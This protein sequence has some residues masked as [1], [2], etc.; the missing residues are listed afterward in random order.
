MTIKFIKWYIG[1]LIK[2][3][4]IINKP[5][6]MFSK[7]LDP[8]LKNKLYDDLRADPETSIVK[9]RDTFE[10][11]I[12]SSNFDMMK[13]IFRILKFMIKDKIPAKPKFYALILIKELMETQ[14]PVIVEYFIKKLMSRLFLIAQFDM[15]NMDIN[16]GE[17]CLK[18]YYSA[19]SKENSDF[20]LKFFMLLLECWKHWQE[21]YADKY[22]KIKE[23]CDKLKP[24]FPLNDIYYDYIE[25]SATK[26]PRN[27]SN[28]VVFN[29]ISEMP[30]DYHPN[31][32]IGMKSRMSVD[33]GDE[34]AAIKHNF[35]QGNSLTSNLNIKGLENSFETRKSLNEFLQGNTEE[36]FYES[37]T[38]FYKLIEVEQANLT[39]NKAS[40]MK[41]QSYDENSKLKYNNEISALTALIEILDKFGRADLNFEDLKKQVRAIDKKYP[42]VS[43]PKIVNKPSS[44]FQKE[45]RISNNNDDEEKINEMNTVKSYSEDLNFSNKKRNQN[46]VDSKSP[47]EYKSAAQQKGRV[48]NFPST[49]GIMEESNEDDSNIVRISNDPGSSRIMIESTEEP[50]NWRTSIDQP[51]PNS[52]TTG[53]TQKIET[54]GKKADK[55]EGQEWA[56]NFES[57]GQEDNAN[58]NAFGEFEGFGQTG[59]SMTQRVDPAKV[60]IKHSNSAKKPSSKGKAN[61]F[62]TK[63]QNDKG[64]EF[65]STKKSLFNNEDPF[66]KEIDEDLNNTDNPFF[67]SDNHRMNTIIEESRED[68]DNSQRSISK[69][70]DPRLQKSI[71]HYSD[72][73]RTGNDDGFDTNI[74]LKFGDF[75]DLI[76]N[77]VGRPSNEDPLM[78][79]ANGIKV[80]GESKN[81]LSGEFHLQSKSM[82]TSKLGEGNTKNKFSNAL[83]NGKG[84]SPIASKN[85]NKFS[86]TPVDDKN[87]QNQSTSR[88]KNP[89]YEDAFLEA[90]RNE[91]SP[92]DDGEVKHPNLNMNKKKETTKTKH[93]FQLVND[94]AKNKDSKHDK[95]NSGNPP[96][97]FEFDFNNIANIQESHKN[98]DEKNNLFEGF[99]NEKPVFG[100]HDFPS[101]ST[102]IN[103]RKLSNSKINPNAKNQPAARNFEE[104]RNDSYNNYE[105]DIKESEV[106]DFHKGDVPFENENMYM[107]DFDHIDRSIGDKHSS[108][109]Y[110][111]KKIDILGKPIA[112]SQITKKTGFPSN[113]KKHTQESNVDQFSSKM[114]L[115]QIGVDHRQNSSRQNIDFNNYAQRSEDSKDQFE[116][117][118]DEE[119]DHF[120]YNREQV[121]EVHP[122]NSANFNMQKMPVT[123]GKSRNDRSSHGKETDQNNSFNIDTK[124]NFELDNNIL[125]IGDA[126][127]KNKN[128]SEQVNKTFMDEFDADQLMRP[129]F[130]ENLPKHITKFDDQLQSG[131]SN[132]PNNFML[133][134]ITQ[135]PLVGDSH[136]NV[137]NSV[138]DNKPERIIKVRKQSKTQQNIGE[139]SNQKQTE[140]K[141]ILLE[142]GNMKEISELKVTN[143][144]L[145]TQCDL[146]FNQL[147]EKQKETLS[148]NTTI[149]K[150]HAHSTPDIDLTE[151]EGKIFQ[152]KNDFLSKE[153]QMLKKMNNS[154]VT[155]TKEKRHKKEEEVVLYGQLNKELEYYI[156]ELQIELG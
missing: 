140:K 8:R 52:Q 59:R 67:R 9:Y 16:R 148:I 124:P 2:R 63:N 110:S 97:E 3:V 91:N 10:K 119:S 150:G 81:S 144:F 139:N 113:F 100:F 66:G 56:F 40:V 138:F 36:I 27:N 62:P 53:K 47:G 80:K 70:F 78:R 94:I 146:L 17:R 122:E 86:K 58:D 44:P 111:D 98:K 43:P 18:K 102:I 92:E 90:L 130:D 42:I 84:A 104:T 128:F 116:D 39:K 153:N 114:S 15:K 125:R 4:N 129:N 24:L 101:N 74:N 72:I 31:E 30:G 107:K 57:V 75:E 112:E 46:N 117:V 141:S 131:Y 151:V 1:S 6:R 155:T 19:E 89:K 64:A 20:S 134:Q 14:K 95:D 77:S 103:E 13:E 35:S 88:N 142:E 135:S 83:K 79:S 60:A 5:K 33:S 51:E 26:Q 93:D 61:N 132:E 105:Y 29:S 133:P 11:E 37:Y 32:S 69:N 108:Y 48:K 25:K 154:L 21:M 23:K 123:F 109:A 156:K 34:F 106:R 126:L 7:P 49:F 127:S 73:S 120:R 45:K 99:D 87:P 68:F 55:K 118:I 28:N 76:E 65:E 149:T 54:K 143:D 38:T 71:K 22:K 41:S 136:L 137:S 82:N 12:D 121:K 115:N 96:I 85:P 145:R 152:R 147:M 50:N